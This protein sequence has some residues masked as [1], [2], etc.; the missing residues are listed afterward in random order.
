MTKTLA[1][2]IPMLESIQ[3]D[4]ENVLDPD[5]INARITYKNR[6]L[7]LMLDSA[8]VNLELTAPKSYRFSVSDLAVQTAERLGLTDVDGY[9][10]YEIPYD[11]LDAHLNGSPL[12]E[13]RDSLWVTCPPEEPERIKEILDDMIAKTPMVKQSAYRNLHGYA[14]ATP[15]GQP[16]FEA[17]L[18]A[19]DLD[20]DRLVRITNDQIDVYFPYLIPEALDDLG[21]EVENLIKGTEASVHITDYIQRNGDKHQDFLAH[22]SYEKGCFHMTIPTN[23]MFEQSRNAVVGELKELLT[24]HRQHLINDFYLQ[25]GLVKYE[26]FMDQVDKVDNLSTCTNVKGPLHGQPTEVTFYHNDDRVMMHI[27]HKEGSPI[28]VTVYDARNAQDAEVKVEAGTGISSFLTLGTLSDLGYLKVG[29]DL[30]QHYVDIALNGLE[31]YKA[32]DAG[33]EAGVQNFVKDL[34][35]DLSDLDLLTSGYQLEQ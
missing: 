19:T 30:C 6:D 33:K 15:D 2:Y 20:D 26:D 24:R 21:R 35:L 28:D 4:P 3:G 22:M 8:G 16:Y 34:G 18:S 1:D 10:T 14:G 27:D 31:N 7:M 5:Y 13:Y 32:S 9:R 17:I 23:G 29:K 25:S 12:R 11:K